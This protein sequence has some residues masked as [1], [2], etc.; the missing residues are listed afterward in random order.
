MNRPTL[1]LVLTCLAPCA[2]AAPQA[3]PVS[4][5][6]VADV[7]QVGPDRSFNLGI[8]LTIEPGW[9]LYWKNPGDAGQPI[10]AKLSASPGVSIAPFRWPVPEKFVPR[11]KVSLTFGAW[12]WATRL[13]AR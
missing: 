1:A 7:A 13:N 6:L 3:G 4:A 2:S 12:A 8:L 10:S 11:R 9:H 5:E